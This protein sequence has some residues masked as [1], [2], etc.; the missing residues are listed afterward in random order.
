M[1]LFDVARSRA[2][3]P[4]YAMCKRASPLQ[5]CSRRSRA[6]R[7][8]AGGGTRATLDR[9][10]ARAQVGKEIAVELKNDVAL[11]GPSAP[12]PFLER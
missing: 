6:A 10:S 5:A 1:V 7:A 8:A 11:T 3:W 4:Q 12:R 2:P 9:L